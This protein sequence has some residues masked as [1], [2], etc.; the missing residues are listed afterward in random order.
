[1]SVEGAD[2][3][4]FEALGTVVG[5]GIYAVTAVIVWDIVSRYLGFGTRWPLEVY[6]YITLWAGL[7]GGAYTTYRDANVRMDLLVE[8]NWL[9]PFERVQPYFAAAVSLV[10]LAFMTWAGISM[11]MNLVESGRVTYELRTPLFVHG[12][13]LPIG[14]GLAGVAV[15]YRMVFGGPSSSGH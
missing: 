14:L 2:S 6:P 5:I 12:A 3:K 7:L 15:I 13:A 9:G 10:Y 11:V 8:E 1:M 4:G